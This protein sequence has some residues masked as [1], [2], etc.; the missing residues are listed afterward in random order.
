VLSPVLPGVVAMLKVHTP[1]SYD[2]NCGCQSLTLPVVRQLLTSRDIKAVSHDLKTSGMHVLRATVERH[3]EVL[4]QV[5][6]GWWF[7]VLS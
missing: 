6:G 5:R 3:L 7:V 4:N 2:L 1:G